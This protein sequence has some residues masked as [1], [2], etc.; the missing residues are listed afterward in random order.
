VEQRVSA[1]AESHYKVCSGR[2]GI[3]VLSFFRKTSLYLLALP[4][5]VW[6]LGFASN[7]A[8]LFANHDKF[9]VMWSDYKAAEYQL[10]LEKAASATDKMGEPTAQAE[11]AQLAIAALESEGFIDEVHCVMT[12]KTHL[13]LLADI[14]DLQSATYSIGDFLL[15]LGEYAF[16]FM[17]PV[18]IFDV[19][20]KLRNT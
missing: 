4:T 2:T 11:Q 18:F 8:V 16:G 19:V 15:M 1:F 14:F 3:T 5:L 20:R 17:L 6:V 9:P 13:N 7:Q 10:D 12:P